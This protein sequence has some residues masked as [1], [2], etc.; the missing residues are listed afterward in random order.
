MPPTIEKDLIAKINSNKK[1]NKNQITGTDE[2]FTTSQ[3]KKCVWRQ[4]LLLLHSD[5][6]RK[7]IWSILNAHFLHFFSI[8]NTK[9]LRG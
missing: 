4:I 2:N 8:L 7:S 6:G 9:R 5:E 1:E 3:I